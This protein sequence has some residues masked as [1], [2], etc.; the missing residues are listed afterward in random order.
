MTRDQLLADLSRAVHAAFPDRAEALMRETERRLLEVVGEEG[1]TVLSFPVTGRNGV[2]WNGSGWNGKG[3]DVIHL[4]AKS[5]GYV[6]A[7]I[8]YRP[9]SM[10][11]FVEVTL[12]RVKP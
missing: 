3:R 1:D 5:I 7:A 8:V 10:R 12:G 11:P 4:T 6:R 9:E 2:E